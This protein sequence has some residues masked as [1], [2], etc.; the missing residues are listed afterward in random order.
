MKYP[1][2]FQDCERTVLSF[3]TGLLGLLS[4]PFDKIKMTW[5]RGRWPRNLRKSGWFSCARHSEKSVTAEI[6]MEN[7]NQPIANFYAWVIFFPDV[8]MCTRML[9]DIWW[10]F[11]KFLFQ[12]S[13]GVVMWELLQRGLTPYPG[14]D[15]LDIKRYLERGERLEKPEQCPSK[16]WVMEQGGGQDTMGK[17]IYVQHGPHKEL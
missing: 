8:R 10:P 13:F 12:W 16:V 15:N 11:Q 14:V 9:G 7:L 1:Q 5:G 4:R 2:T 6:W 17:P 3:D